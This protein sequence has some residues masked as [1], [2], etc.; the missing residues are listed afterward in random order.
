MNLTLAFH[1]ELTRTN[2]KPIY[3]FGPQQHH[4]RHCWRSRFH[5]QL[6][7][8]WYTCAFQLYTV[9]GGWSCFPCCTF[10]FHRF[11]VFAFHLLSLKVFHVPGIFVCMRW[12]FSPVLKCMKQNHAVH[13]NLGFIVCWPFSSPFACLC[14]LLHSIFFF[15]HWCQMVPHFLWSIFDCTLLTQ[16]ITLLP[17]QFHFHVPA[18]SI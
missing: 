17:L 5:K 2:R 16:T 8:F 3:T 4:L 7:L 13:H 11:T 1:S 15:L 6:N 10:F 14:R 18:I 9:L 12:Y